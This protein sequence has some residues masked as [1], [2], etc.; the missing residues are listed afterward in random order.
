MTPKGKIARLPHALREQV[1]TRLLDGQTAGTILAWLNP[2]PEAIRTW[3]TYFEGNPATE[4]NLS[5]WRK[6]GYQRWLADRESIENTKALA[7]FAA[8]QAAAGNNLSAGL[9]AILAGHLMEGFE[10]LASIAGNPDAP[11]DPVKR[12]ATLGGVITSL[13][14]ADTAAAKL[15]LDKRRVHQRDNELAL[16]RQKYQRQTCEQ[17][18]KAAK[19]K[20]IQDILASG[21]TKAIQLDLIHAQLF[22]KAPSE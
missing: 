14:N 18:W 8:H 17:V 10:V 5:E 20:E 21:K 19:S 1:C 15:D 6:A 2:L 12:I 11:D 4:Q 9:Q 3:D 16:A 22:G 7:T 13:R